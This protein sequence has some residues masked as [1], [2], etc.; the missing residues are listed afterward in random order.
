MTTP[1]SAPT[2]TT[3]VLVPVKAFHQAKVRL[4]PSLSAAARAELARRMAERV[5]A[6]AHGL[7]VWVVCD[8]DA[9]ADWA[10]TAGASVS[11]QPGVGLNEAVNTAVA[12]RGEAGVARVIVAH[13]DLPLAR[14][15][16]WLADEP[17]DIILVPDRH[18]D[19][20]NVA[21]LPTACGFQFAYGAG[22]FVRHRRAAE[23]LG[24]DVRVRRDAELG[25]DVDVPDD[26]GAAADLT[27]PL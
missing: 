3:E 25:W 22:S 15:L 21:V 9:V 5:V 18:D 24:L 16:R 17:G 11:W 12:V 1:P 6:A 26:L 19:G 20:T 4:A 2:P 13:G 10:R 27:T 7:A 14:D 23:E 8:D